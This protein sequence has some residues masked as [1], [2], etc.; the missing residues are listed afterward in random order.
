MVHRPRTDTKAYLTLT[1]MLVYASLHSQEIALSVRS[2]RNVLA[3]EFY[4][5]CD[6]YTYS[7]T[8]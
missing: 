1:K 7:Y 6:V 4:I 8:C 3:K 5:L 2:Y